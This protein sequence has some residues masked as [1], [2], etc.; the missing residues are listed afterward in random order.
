M[1]YFFFSLLS[2]SSN[3]V[4]LS[5]AK[6]DST[7]G[8]FIFLLQRWEVSE[9]PGFPTYGFNSKLVFICPFRNQLLRPVW[10][11]TL[12][13]F[14]SIDTEQ[15]NIFTINCMKMWW[16][17]VAKKQ[18]DNNSIKT[19]LFQACLFPFSCHVIIKDSVV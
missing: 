15:T 2:N 9:I 8:Y 3:K 19:L 6:A 18:F 5:I 10:Q 17:M 4:R 11:I 14:E 1:S 12:Y 13:H 7:F 16:R